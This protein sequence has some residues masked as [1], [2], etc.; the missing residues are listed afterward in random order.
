[1]LDINQRQLGDLQTN[2]SVNFD[3]KWEA[4]DFSINSWASELL[5]SSNDHR[6]LHPKVINTPNHHYSE[7]PV[8][9]TAFAHFYNAYHT[10][11][12]LSLSL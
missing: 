2:L 12:P 3:T 5:I 11:P 8:Q 10:T 4:L 1:M 9:P 7:N 6:L